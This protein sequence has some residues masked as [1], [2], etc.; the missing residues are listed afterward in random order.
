M[1][2]WEIYAHATRDLLHNLTGKPLTDENNR[3]K[4]NILKFMLGQTNEVTV[5]SKTWTFP[6]QKT[7]S[8]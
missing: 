6:Y 1:E 2:K 7:K 3:D 5:G 8:N 4:M